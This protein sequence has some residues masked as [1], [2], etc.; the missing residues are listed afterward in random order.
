MPKEYK[1]DRKYLKLET[2][3]NVFATCLLIPK[4]LL[5]KELDEGFDL[6]IEDDFKKLCKKFDVSGAAMA[7]RF[8]LLGRSQTPLTA[9][10]KHLNTEISK[11]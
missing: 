5:L 11:S 9:W 4:D 8:Y 6:S 2:E 3:A 1:T 10:K 7:F